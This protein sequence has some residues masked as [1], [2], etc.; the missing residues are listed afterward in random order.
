MGKSDQPERGLLTS[1]NRGITCCG[2]LFT[3][4]LGLPILWG[5]IGFVLP[6]KVFWFPFW[7]TSVVWNGEDGD[8]GISSLWG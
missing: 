6:E 7:L 2:C 3:A 4:L 8:G 1:V 5:M